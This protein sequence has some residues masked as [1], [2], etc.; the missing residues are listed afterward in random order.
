MGEAKA[1]KAKLKAKMKADKEKNKSRKRKAAGG[2]S[3]GRGGKSVRTSKGRAP[4]ALDSRLIQSTPAGFK[5]F[6]AFSAGKGES[7]E[8]VDILS[9][10]QFS[11]T[12]PMG[13]NM[14]G[15]GS[16]YLL[17]FPTPSSTSNSHDLLDGSTTVAA[18]N[19]AG[20][21]AAAVSTAANGSSSSNSISDLMVIG[22]G[23]SPSQKE[24]LKEFVHDPS[25][26]SKLPASGNFKFPYTPYGGEEVL[27]IK[28]GLLSTGQENRPPSATPFSPPFELLTLDGILPTPFSPVKVGE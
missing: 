22:T 1:A 27:G 9:S 14:F 11:P 23:I 19:A 4:P 28:G 16:Q 15:S 21:T 17:P 18:A 26:I 20:L 25:S 7:S 10:M 24:M 3:K 5:R 13:L 2:K 6:N 8:Y 12:T